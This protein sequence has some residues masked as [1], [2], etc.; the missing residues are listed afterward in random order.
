[1]VDDDGRP[2]ELPWEDWRAGDDRDTSGWMRATAPSGE[3]TFEGV[4]AW[5]GELGYGVREPEPDQATRDAA[6][7]EPDPLLIE[8]VPAAHGHGGDHD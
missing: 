6:G 3:A 5:S 2:K 7:G 4:T 8:D 1:M